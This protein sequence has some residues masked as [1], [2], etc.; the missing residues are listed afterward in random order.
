MAVLFFCFKQKTAYEMR[1]SDWRSDVCSSDLDQQRTAEA[2]EARQGAQ[3]REVVVDRLAEA[4]AGIEDQP[5][6][7]DA[8]GGAG[9]DATFQIGQHLGDH[10]IVMRGR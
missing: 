6:A 2:V 10:I 4:D 5:V 9:G 7:R 3:Q 1:I 8:G